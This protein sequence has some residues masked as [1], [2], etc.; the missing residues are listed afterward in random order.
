MT[1]AVVQEDQFSFYVYRERGARHHYPHCHIRR[2][3]G[4]A[5][6]VISLLS[7]TVLAGPKPSSAERR[8]LRDNREKLSDAWRRQNE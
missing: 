3:D 4:S 5:E 8:A 1:P 6:T 7:L 2:R